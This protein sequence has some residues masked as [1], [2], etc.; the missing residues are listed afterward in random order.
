MASDYW[1]I[2]P[3]KSQEAFAFDNMIPIEK[4]MQTTSKWFHTYSESSSTTWQPKKSIQ[5]PRKKRKEK[6]CD[7]H[8]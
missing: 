1:P 4:G 6:S 3:I 5:W 7:L 8:N 2:H